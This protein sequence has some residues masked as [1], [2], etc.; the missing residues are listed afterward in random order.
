MNLFQKV[1]SALTG[2]KAASTPSSSAPQP[3]TEADFAPA[4]QISALDVLSDRP[5]AKAPPQPQAPVPVAAP[6]TQAEVDEIMSLLPPDLRQ[7]S[8]EQETT[9]NFRPA[10]SQAAEPMVSSLSAFLADGARHLDVPTAPAPQAAE[11]AYAPAPPQAPAPSGDAHRLFEAPREPGAQRRVLPAAPSIA[12][13]AEIQGFV[14][15]CLVDG[16]SGLMLASE[17]G[18]QIDMEVAAALNSQVMKAER[19]AMALMGLDDHIEDIL[20]TLGRQLHFL[21]PLEANPDMFVYVALD[22]KTANLGM[23]RMQINRLEATLGS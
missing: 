4:L 1:G 8:S 13:A 21:R 19:K 10:P 15:A 18:G 20:V 16:E 12:A 17:G 14:G 11:P 3:A 7:G 23:A 5:R 6:P 2:G 22:K 9:S